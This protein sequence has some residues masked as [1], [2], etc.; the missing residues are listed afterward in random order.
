MNKKD[1]F[2]LVEALISITIIS[3]VIISILNG[4]T[5]QQLNTKNTS[6]KNIA[7]SLAEVKLEEL[8]KFPGSQLSDSTTI[9]YIVQE[10]NSLQVY[11]SDPGKEKQLRRT[12]LI[13]SVGNLKSF[14]V[15]VEYGKSG[16]IYPFSINLS[17]QRG[18]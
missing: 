17:T 12:T 16:N 18:G 15:T 5:Y 1:G 14:R 9:D 4:F 3:F 10:G 7:V 2:T 11:T 8:L 13:A 6:S